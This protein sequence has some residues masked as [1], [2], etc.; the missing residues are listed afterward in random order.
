M[1]SLRALLVALTLA[2]VAARAP[3]QAPAKRAARRAPPPAPLNQ[4]SLYDCDDARAPLNFGWSFSG[5]AGGAGS[6]ALAGT[7]LCASYD[8]ATTNLYADECAPAAPTQTFTIRADGTFFNAATGLCWD[9][10]YYGNVSGA[11]LGLY[12]CSEESWGTFAYSAATS[13]ITNTQLTTLCVNGG[14][15]PVPAPTKEQ[16]AWM[17]NEIS[18]MISYDMITQLPDVPNGQHFC[19]EAGADTDN[20]AVPPATSFNPTALNASNWVAAAAASGAGYTLLVAS[21]CAGFLQW[22]T[23]VTLPNGTLYPYGVAQAT[24]WRGGRGDVVADYV[25]ASRAAGVGFGFYLTWNY[26]YLFR[27]G[28]RGQVPGPLAPGQIELTDDEYA[29]TMY[30]TIE[31]VWS[32]YPGAITEVWL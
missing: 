17:D 5:P 8:A 16:L 12:T 27:R 4:L 32:R 15:A 29:D 23:N 11:T 21:H 26:N 10:Q 14:G 9:S 20:F 22:Q 30:K 13:R 7:S 3:R 31:E 1:A 25:E 24:D 6:F 18:L 2:T 19:Y 28:P